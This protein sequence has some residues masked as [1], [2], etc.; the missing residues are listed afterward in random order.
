MMMKQGNK[1]DEF[2]IAVSTSNVEILLIYDK[3]ILLS[4]SP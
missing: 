1:I 2:I 3:Y 4:L